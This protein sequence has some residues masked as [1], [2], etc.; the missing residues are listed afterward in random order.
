MI[1]SMRRSIR[2][3]LVVIAICATCAEAQ[4]TVKKVPPTFEQ[5]VIDPKNPPPEK[6]NVAPNHPAFTWCNYTARWFMRYNTERT[7]VQD[8]KTTVRLTVSSMDLTL[9]LNSTIWLPAGAPQ[10]L[11]RHEQGHQQIG[12]RSY[13]SADT[14]ARQVAQEIVVGHTFEASAGD[15]A[16]A[17]K[18]ASDK[19]GQ[20]FLAAYLKAIRDPAQRVHQLYDEITNHGNNRN[21]TEGDA[22]EQ[23]IERYRAERRKPS[24]TTTAAADK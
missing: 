18:A 4:V 1:Y 19:A 23:A 2:T 3:A 7:P 22:V 14:I 6:K 24:P 10:R 20:A 5:K 11:F 12:E 15:V 21:V 13:G 17:E 8:G 9:S 16:S